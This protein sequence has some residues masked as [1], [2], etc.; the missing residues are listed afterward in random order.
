MSCERSRSLSSMKFKK[1]ILAI[2]LVLSVMC[3]SLLCLTGCDE[4]DIYANKVRVVFKLEGGTY[5]STQNDVIYYL[6]DKDGSSKKVY[7][8]VATTGNE[9]TNADYT[10]VGWF[11]DR[12]DDGDNVIY[13]NKWDFESDRVGDDGV[14]LYACW[15]KYTYNV[16]FRDDD[17]A[18]QV[19]GEYSV[20]QGEKFDDYKNFDESRSGYTSLG[21]YRTESGEIWD[22][23]FEHPGGDLDLAVN[24]VVDYLKGDYKLIR[25]ARELR[26]NRN[27][28]IYLMNDIDFE[29]EKFAGFG[30]YR[31]TFNGNGYTIKNFV[32]DYTG[33]R[34]SLVNNTDLEND[35]NH[36][37]RNL[38]VLS[39][40]GNTNGARVENVKFENVSFDV[41]TTFSSTA[42]IYVAPLAL[43][44][45][46]SR[47]ADVTFD[48]IVSITALPAKFDTSELY[49][50]DGPCYRNI[51]DSSFD[52]KITLTRNSKE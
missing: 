37:G 27:G 7:D 46:N 14:T 49:I 44:A 16:C 28:N 8:P 25:T 35:G 29:G 47:F 13:K 52:C 22:S 24:V 45:R 43:T 38:L 10:F 32:F 1:P 23:D 31:G 33:G 6:G 17:G 3:L 15:R 34:D 30:N 21:V 11:R 39:L 2:I 18:L 26:A 50:A 19:L 48:G 40:F 5:R 9:M 51:D 4:P 36:N 20:S 42:G 41:N 12:I